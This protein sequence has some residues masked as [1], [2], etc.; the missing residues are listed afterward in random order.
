MLHLVDDK[1]LAPICANGG[2]FSN[3][4]IQNV[5]NQVRRVSEPSESLEP[6]SSRGT[7]LEASAWLNTSYP[8]VSERGGI[9]PKPFGNHESQLVFLTIGDFHPLPRLHKAPNG[10]WEQHQEVYNGQ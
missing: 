6:S 9:N 1:F 3:S 10:F 7:P 8:A 2:T 5:S 4:K